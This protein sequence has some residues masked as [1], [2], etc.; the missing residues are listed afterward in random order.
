MPNPDSF[1]AR[2]GRLIAERRAGRFTQGQLAA[3]V[4][5]GDSQAEEKRKGD[6]SKLENGKVAKPN[7]TTVERIRSVLGIELGEIEDLRRQSQLSTAQQLAE[8]PT[9]SQEELENLAARFGFA[10]PYDISPEKL[11]QFLSEKAK[12]YRALKA[13]IDAI[14]ERVAGLGNLKAAAKAAMEIPDFEEVETLLARVDEVETE[15]VAESKELRAQNALLRN[16]P[17]EAF[18]HFSAAADAFANIDPLEP[19]RRRLRYMQHLYQHGMRYGGAG[20]ALSAETTRAALTTL[21]EAETPWDWA[22]AQNSLAIALRNQGSRTPGPEGAALLAEA[23]EAYRAA[24]RVFTEADHPVDWAGTMQNLAGALQT[25]GG[26]TPGPDGAALL[27]EA[28]E[29]YRAALRVRTEADHPVDWAMTMQNLAGALQAQGTRTSGPEGAALLDEAA[30]AYRAAL[31]VS[32]EADHPVHWATTMQNLAVALRNQGARTSGPEGAA[33]LDE[34]ARA[35][36]A[37]LRVRT[38]ADHPVD[39]AMTMQNL[40][41]VLEEQG[42]RTSGPE[43]AALLAEAADAYRAALRVFTEADHP[44]NWARTM[45]NLAGALQTQGTR[46]SGPEGGALLAEAARAYRAALCVRTEADHPAQWAM[47][48]ENM[49]LLEVARADHDTCTDPRVALEAALGHVEAALTVYDDTM[50]F[51]LDKATELRDALKTR[52]A[53]L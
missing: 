51:F 23:V 1:G 7:P 6:I 14:D 25:Q 52:L 33:L 2:F 38:E 20:L 19:A 11:R 42:T 45:Q 26:R 30:R 47:T 12:D 21:S 43:G 34:A 46:T 8:I 36:R 16:R 24:L 35:Y 37:A 49:A 29:A 41:I 32:T 48:Q 22:N 3:R 17:E 40:G 13:Q 28:V 9:L 4:W 18:K 15:I 39:W 44:V 27:A 53:A 5:P 50:G 10:D 31:R